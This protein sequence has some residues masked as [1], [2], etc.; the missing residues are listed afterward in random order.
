M[1]RKNRALITRNS[2]KDDRRSGDKARRRPQCPTALKV[3]DMAK[4]R[5]ARF[6]MASLVSSDTTRGGPLCVPGRASIASKLAGKAT[7]IGCPG[8]TLLWTLCQRIARGSYDVPDLTA[9]Q[10]ILENGADV[11][12]RCSSHDRLCDCGSAQRLAED[13]ERRAQKASQV[14]AAKALARSAA[15]PQS[16]WYA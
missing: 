7:A 16:E 10:E 4:P 14:D 5:G 13:Y 3:L 15:D 1:R 6:A 12:P 11:A 9:R 2:E 8:F